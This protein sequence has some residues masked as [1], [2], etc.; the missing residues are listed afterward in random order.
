[1]LTSFTNPI[2]TSDGGFG[3]TIA[4]VGSD[5]VLIGSPYNNTG[6]TG[7]GAAYLYNTNGALLTTFTNPFPATSDNFGTSV[8]GGRERPGAHQRD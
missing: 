6:A 1:M 4:A 5:R 7:A 8:A 2:P 3:I